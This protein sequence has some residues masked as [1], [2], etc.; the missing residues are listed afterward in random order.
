VKYVHIEAPKEECLARLETERHPDDVEELRKVIEDYFST[1]QEQRFAPAAPNVERRFLGNFSQA[2]KAD[3]NLLRVER[4]SDP[5][6]GKPRTYIVGY[7]ATFGRDS[8]LLGD[9]VERIEPSAFDIVAKREDGE[10]KPLE[11]RCLFNHSPDHLL[12][13]FPTTMRMTVDEKGLKYECLLPESRSDLAELIE[14]GDLKGSSFSF[15]IADGGERWTVED[16]RSIRVVT[17]IKSLL[18]CGPVTYPAYGDASV[19]VAKRSYEQFCEQRDC[20]RDDG[21]KFG[22]G[23]KCQKDGEGG[24]ESES[25]KK[26]LSGTAKGALFGAAIGA[27][28]G[29]GAIPGAAVGA[30]L[31]SLSRMFGKSKE[32]LPKMSE[33]EAREKLAGMMQASKI[34]N[35]TKMMNDDQLTSMV[36]AAG[37]E[38]T[39]KPSG[40]GDQIMISKPD[41]SVFHVSNA[42]RGEGGKTTLM[43]AGKGQALVGSNNTAQISKPIDRA[44]ISEAERLAKS[45]GIKKVVLFINEGDAK[46]QSA[47]SA[48]GGFSKGGPAGKGFERYSKSLSSP[49]KRS[50]GTPTSERAA[51]VSAE[52]RQFLESRNCGT[53]SGGFQKGNSCGGAGGG[54]TASKKEDSNWR[55]GGAAGAL[56]GGAIGGIA[57]LPAAAAGAVAG[58]VIGAIGGMYGNKGT[59]PIDTAMENVRVSEK[60]LDKAAK[61][62]GESMTITG[63]GKTVDVRGPSVDFSLSKNVPS[64]LGH[65]EDAAEN[66]KVHADF[67]IKPTSNATPKGVIAASKAVKADYVTVQV[68]APA[69]KELFK[70]AGF[71]E[72]G[73]SLVYGKSYDPEKAF[74]RSYDELASFLAERRDCGRDEGGKFGSGNECQNDA[75]GEKPKYMEWKKGDHLKKDKPEKT[76]EFLDDAREGQLARG[77]KDGGKSDDGGGVQT[78]SKG[79]DYPW[80]TQQVGT[81]EGY[82][83][84]RH[85]DGSKTGKYP[86]SKGDTSAASEALKNELK[87]KKK[88]RA[89]DVAEETLRF[90]RERARM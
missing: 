74:R 11:T 19:S 52:M 82:L 63:D 2:E 90:L 79:D 15:V 61:S 70:A 84:A 64:D 1:E 4:R 67:R 40:K 21:G 56:V 45:A 83:Q 36:R 50:A 57:G 80:T 66:E 28:L 26:G 32:S 5:Q 17:A 8:L 73:G 87:K 24:G 51:K 27:I 68:S 39:F 6:S 85:P 16:G 75:T 22:S 59:K 33:G 31:G 13:R 34:A 9:F 60:K 23:N 18:D 71:K 55:E 58:A 65:S 3:P 14:R 42:M 89:S 30:V 43:Y 47:I 86:F 12:G 29:P 44:G 48:T 81:D 88:S 25:E 10:G 76:Q 7:A 35:K 49:S 54:P 62:L 77:G 72:Q 38:A 46:S 20:G 69:Q 37:P 53:G 41:G 78:W